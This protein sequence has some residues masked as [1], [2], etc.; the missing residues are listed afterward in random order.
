M[1]KFDQSSVIKDFLSDVAYPLKILEPRI[2]IG[3]TV[4]G[5]PAEICNSVSVWQASDR[6]LVKHP[7][8]K[9]RPVHRL[10]RW[11]RGDEIKRKGI[12][13]FIRQL[14]RRF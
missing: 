14:K 2:E 3:L 13:Q 8:C 1:I 6:H 11:N 4:L 9:T 10:A 12:T 5:T 7:V